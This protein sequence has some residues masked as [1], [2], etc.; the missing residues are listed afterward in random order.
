MRILHIAPYYI[1]AYRYGGPIY[2][3]HGLCRSLAAVGH[4]V[5][6][7][8]T[9]VDGPNESEVPYDSPVGLDRVQIHYCR[10]GVMRRLFWSP[11]LYARC[12]DIV[13]G[14]D[15]VHL[16][17]VF[18][19]PTWAG[20]QAAS[21]A[22]VPY[23]LSPR[24]MLVGE[25][26]ERRNAV[27]K[28]VWIQLVERRNLRRAAAIHVTSEEERRAIEDLGLALAR[29]A[30]IHNGVDSPMS[31]SPNTVSADVRRLVAAGFDVLSFGR[32]SWKKGLDRLIRSMAEMQR[33]TVL[34]AGPSEDGLAER[35]RKLAEQCGI[36]DR[37]LLLP[38]Q[39]TGPDKEA[40]FAAARL[41]A[42]PSLSENFGN[43]VAEAMIRGLPV[44]VTAGVGAAEVLVESGG[45]VVAPSDPK[46]FAAIVSELLGSHERRAFMAAAGAA[47]ARERL[48]W[49]SIARRFEDLYTETARQRFGPSGMH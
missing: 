23:V 10:S 5:H 29:T 35:L 1:P 49:N 46:G 11:S 7:L 47:Y 4:D 8:T 33:P 3:V 45:G 15:A 36:S 9:G 13:S 31:F 2:S 38:R 20:A 43:V 24:G 39:V 18:Q 30:V 40:L 12:S 21:K 48:S 26:I 25:L 41:F 32:I 16:H 37:V 17:T 22:G 42:L 44:V 6:V 28:R 27:T 14:F 19:F 34:I